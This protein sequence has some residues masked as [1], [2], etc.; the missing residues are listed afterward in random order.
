MLHVRLMLRKNEA[1]PFTISPDANW[2]TD[3]LF[4][5][6]SERVLVSTPTEVTIT[7]EGQPHGIQSTGRVISTQ[8]TPPEGFSVKLLDLTE[9][10]RSIVRSWVSRALSESG[11]F[12][13]GR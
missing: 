10:D 9:N 11:E 8:T 5:Q 1:Q 12:R 3:C 13:G 6:S 2:K 4:V 7:L